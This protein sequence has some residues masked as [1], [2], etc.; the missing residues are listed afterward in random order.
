MRRDVTVEAPTA[1]GFR[2]EAPTAQASVRG[3]PIRIILL[4]SSPVFEA[5]MSAI[6]LLAS[7][8][9]VQPELAKRPDLLLGLRRLLDQ[10][11]AT[12]GTHHHRRGRPR[13][14]PAIDDVKSLH[15]IVADYL[16]VDGRPTPA[17][18]DEANAL[19]PGLL[20]LIAAE[21]G[22]SRRP[23]VRAD[24]VLAAWFSVPPSRIK[25]YRRS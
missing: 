8:E 4:P 21:K 11:H 16:D 25:R 2:V 17:Q 5:Y 14:G 15:L 18:A 24:E 7:G 23:A 3:L 22:S 20:S 1:R 12:L 13:K 10:A 19:A 9:P 6:R